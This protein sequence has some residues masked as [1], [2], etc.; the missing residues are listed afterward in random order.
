MSILSLV[1]QQAVLI[2]WKAL[3][4]PGKML[5]NKC[6]SGQTVPPKLMR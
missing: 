3:T 5:K 2:S 6:V 1:A 4:W